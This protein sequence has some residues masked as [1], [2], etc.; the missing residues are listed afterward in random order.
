[1]CSL[2]C[3]DL[4]ATKSLTPIESPYLTCFQS[5]YI[6]PFPS[7]IQHDKHMI[8]ASYI[9]PTMGALHE[10]PCILHVHR[11]CQLIH[12][13]AQ[14]SSVFLLNEIGL[15]PGI[16]HCSAHSLLTRLREE[17]KHVQSFTSFCGSSPGSCIY[18]P[19]VLYYFAKWPT[20]ISERRDVFERFTPQIPSRP[21]SPRRCST[22]I[23]GNCE[24][25]QFPVCENVW[26]RRDE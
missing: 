19:C 20:T 26:A 25:G 5:L 1:M 6:P 9:S 7:S 21:S 8:T 17:R 22:P 14:S 16:D 2:I 15:D 10:S 23:R 18:W 4:C 3:E 11:V 12:T 13:S 24:Q